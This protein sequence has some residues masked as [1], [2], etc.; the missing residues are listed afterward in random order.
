MIWREWKKIYLK[1]VREF[2]YSVSEDLKAAKILNNLIHGKA[3]SI[4]YLKKIFADKS[5]IVVFGAGPSLEF[6][7]E[8]FL[9]AGILEISVIVVVDGASRLFLEKGLRVDPAP[10]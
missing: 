6:D 5:L 7:L 2:N 8:E 10:L 1:I 3:C 4:R 9:E